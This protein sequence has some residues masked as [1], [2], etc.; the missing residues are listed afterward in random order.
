MDVN[1]PLALVR[2]QELSGSVIDE[3]PK[4]ANSGFDLRL[5]KEL[6]NLSFFKYLALRAIHSLPSESLQKTIFRTILKVRIFLN[7]SRSA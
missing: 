5:E 3:V 2:S 6:F 1:H 7:N 4:V